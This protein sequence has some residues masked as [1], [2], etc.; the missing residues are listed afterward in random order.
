MAAT[1]VDQGFYWGSVIRSC[2]KRLGE[3]YPVHLFLSDQ[4]RRHSA[5][6]LPG[7]RSHFRTRNDFPSLLRILHLRKIYS[8]SS[9]RNAA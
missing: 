4:N 7:L 1:A 3:K 2:Q 9:V 5:S 8:E 6:L